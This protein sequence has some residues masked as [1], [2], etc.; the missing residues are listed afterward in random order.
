MRDLT[1]I[2]AAIVEAGLIRLRP[3]TIYRKKKAGREAN[4]DRPRKIEDEKPNTTTRGR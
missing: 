4:R 3:P 2:V 1:L